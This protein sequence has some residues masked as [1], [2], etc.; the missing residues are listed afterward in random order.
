MFIG[1]D[2]HGKTLGIV[3]MGR[4]GSAMVPRAKG[5]DMDIIYYD[6]VRN[7]EKERELKLEYRTLEDVLESSDFV[8]IQVP[9][10]TRNPSYDQLGAAPHDEANSLPR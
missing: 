7:T 4:I 9:P 6:C 10:D 8:S 5:F 2:I 3:V 1:G